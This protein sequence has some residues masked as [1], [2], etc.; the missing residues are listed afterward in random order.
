[1]FGAGDV[2]LAFSFAEILVRAFFIFADQPGAVE[3]CGGGDAFGIAGGG[4]QRVGAAHA[5]AMG[6]DRAFFRRRLGID[7]CQDVGEI[8]HHR[9][10]RHLG[11]DCAHPRL[12]GAPLGGDVGAVFR[13]S[14]GA[15]V[16]VGQHDIVAGGA[17]A[18]GHVVKFLADAGGVHQQDDH[19]EWAIAFGMDDESLHRASSRLE[20]ADCFDHGVFLVVGVMVPRHGWLGKQPWRMAL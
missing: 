1:M 18:A 9:R 8:L 13:V 11:A 2:E 10:D 17:E 19:R 4:G 12:L 14:A 3:G 15:I 16:K 6:A 5:I 20:I 7:E